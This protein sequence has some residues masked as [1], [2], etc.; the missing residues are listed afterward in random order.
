MRLM[1]FVPG[2]ESSK[3]PYRY[4][5]PCFICH[6]PTLTFPNP[7]WY[8]L[9]VQQAL[10]HDHDLTTE[11][12]CMMFDNFSSTQ[13]RPNKLYVSS[14]ILTV[15]DLVPGSKTSHIAIHKAQTL[16]THTCP[17][18]VT[19]RCKT[20]R[21]CSVGHNQPELRCGI[22]STPRSSLGPEFPSTVSHQALGTHQIPSPQQRG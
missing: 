7:E 4:L 20:T 2:K 22:I 14:S 12:T 11:S 5:I 21:G 1:P 16:K 13:W 19:P 9:L 17:P 3:L 18:L 10:Q 8:V 15:I 6:I